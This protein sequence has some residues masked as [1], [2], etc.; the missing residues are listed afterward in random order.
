M[1]RVFINFIE[2][3]GLFHSQDSILLALSGGIDSMVMAEL[4]R[5]SH[6]SYKILHCN[7][8]LRAADSEADAQF[9]RDYAA[10]YQIPFLEKTF[11]L[12]T[13]SKDSTQM[14]ARKLR[15]A[16][17]E[18]LLLSG[19][20]D[21]VA[22]AHHLDDALETLIL[23]LTRGSGLSG[24][25][26]IKAQRAQFVRPLLFSDKAQIR[27]YAAQHNLAWREDKSNASTKYRRNHIRHKV[28]PELQKL[29]P[30]LSQTFSNT[31]ERLQSSE[32]LLEATLSRQKNSCAYQ[33][34]ERLV[35]ELEKLKKIAEP[36]LTLDYIL[37]G[38][39][40][41]Y[42]QSQEIW[43]TREGLSGRRFLSSGFILLCNREEW[44][45][46]PK[47]LSQLSPNQIWHLSE[48]DDLLETSWFRLHFRK[49]AYTSDLTIKLPPEQAYLDADKLRFPLELRVW[50]EGERFRPL[51]LGGSQKISDF[52]INQKVARNLKDQTL[53]LL[54]AGKIV[55]L[56]GHRIDEDF[57]ITPQTQCVFHLNY[58][59]TSFK[60]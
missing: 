1:Y 39:G 14:Q 22:T 44:C 11:S 24:I 35:I 13:S 54:S 7:F 53:V 41:N 9:L 10:K 26:A 42:S 31:W 52:L 19:E 20:G 60:N 6:F 27:A 55:W 2:K 56:L 30:K 21:K 18:E 46:Y 23:N 45:V 12:D 32:R 34:G 37:Q 5:Q 50:Q 8:Q 47:N 3:E 57:K 43:A 51:G 28:I 33:K 58:S 36:L 40:F 38:Y 16:W 25:S 17:F 49:F 15:Y 4:F 48:N 29:N 59:K